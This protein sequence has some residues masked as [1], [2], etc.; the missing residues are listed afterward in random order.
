MFTISQSLC[1]PVNAVL[2]G[3]LLY[4]SRL[5]PRVPPMLGFI[6]APLLFAAD[7]AVLFDLISMHSP[8]AGLGYPS[9]CPCGGG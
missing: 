4:R 2:L 8:L 6:G 9:P 1:P 7:I 5:V 3:S